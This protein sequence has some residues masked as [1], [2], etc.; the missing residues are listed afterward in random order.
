MNRSWGRCRSP[1]RTVPHVRG[2]EPEEAAAA[3]ANFSLF[4]TCVGMNRIWIYS[5]G[6]R[7]AVP[8]VRGDEPCD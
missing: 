1:C 6:L 3:R 8:H 5:C 4:P 2:D 7:L